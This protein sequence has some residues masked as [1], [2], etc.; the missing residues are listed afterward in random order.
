M[1]ADVTLSVEHYDALLIGWSSQ[2]VQNGNIFEAGMSQYSPSSQ[3]ARDILTSVPNNWT[4]NDGNVVGAPSC[5]QTETPG[6]Q[7]V[8]LNVNGTDRDVLFYIPNGYESL[9]KV[10]MTFSLH[11]SNSNPEAHSNLTD[12]ETYADMHGYVIA[13]IL[14]YNN[15]WNTPQNDSKPHDVDFAKEIIQYAETNFCVDSNSVFATGYSGGARTSSRITCDLGD[16]IRAMASV[17]GI[18]YDEPCLEQE[19]PILALH[20]RNDS[21]NTYPGNAR[22]N[23]IEG[24]ED[25]V[26]D[27]RLANGCSATMISTNPYTDVELRSW[28]ECN[29]EAEIQFYVIEDKG[30][31]YNQIPITTSVIFDFF[32][33]FL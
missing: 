1:F 24:V 22:W 12:I 17:S 16:E 2:V 32:N 21:I 29:G 26:E 14:G 7:W 30:H 13:S 9:D 11:G 33:S 23:W 15:V 19:T 25:A 27:W 10:P 8:T 4:I 5:T 3:A 20:S 31:S 6:R 18:R 28:N